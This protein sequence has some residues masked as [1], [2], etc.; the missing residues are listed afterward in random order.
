[1]NAPSI[2]PGLLW[3]PHTSPLRPATVSLPSSPSSFFLPPGRTPKFLHPEDG[4]ISPTTS[5]A[6]WPLFLLSSAKRSPSNTSA[7]LSVCLIAYFSHWHPLASSLPWSLPSALRAAHSSVLW[8]DARKKAAAAS[9]RTSC[10]PHPRMSASSGM[11][12]GSCVS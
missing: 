1:M 12:R 11:G 4:K 3:A 5:A 9:K 8:S 6:T 7:K 2:I 10:R